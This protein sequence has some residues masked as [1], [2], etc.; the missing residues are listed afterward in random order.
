MC[1]ITTV[2]ADSYCHYHNNLDICSVS[3]W[4]LK[5]KKNHMVKTRRKKY[6]PIFSVAYRWLTQALITFL[7]LQTLTSKQSKNIK[8]LPRCNGEGNHYAGNK[9]EVQLGENWSTCLNWCLNILKRAG[10]FPPEPFSLDNSPDNS[11]FD[12]SYVHGLINKKVS[13]KIMHYIKSVS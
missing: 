1:V 4:T 13:R 10:T 9:F 8:A 2:L 12:N 6:K 7:F 5:E 11:P 3:Y